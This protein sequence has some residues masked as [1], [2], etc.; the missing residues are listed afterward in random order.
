MKKLMKKW[1]TLI[2][3]V[4]IGLSASLFISGCE[5]DSDLEDAAEDT[6]EAVEDATEDT[7][8]GIEDAAEEAD[9]QL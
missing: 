9:D 5:N 8:E 7:A 4:M 1:T 6:Q 3:M 2:M